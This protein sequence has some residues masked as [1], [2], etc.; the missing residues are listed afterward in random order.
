[1]E[2]ENCGFPQDRADFRDAASVPSQKWASE[3]FYPPIKLSEYSQPGEHSELRQ[4]ELRC[5]QVPA[6]GRRFLMISRREA[7]PDRLTFDVT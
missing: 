3:H 6:N 7:I 5:R 4:S 2:A 1:M